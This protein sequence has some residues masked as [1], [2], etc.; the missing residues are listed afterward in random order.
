[1]KLF[2][3]TMIA[4]LFIVTSAQSGCSSE[5]ACSVAQRTV[6]SLKAAAALVCTTDSLKP[7]ECAL[8]LAALEEAGVEVKRACGPDDPAVAEAVAALRAAAPESLYQLPD[9]RRKGAK[10]RIRYALSVADDILRGAP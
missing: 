10:K 4:F 7:G 5:D 2:R 8:I 9:E 1:M 3:L 6:S